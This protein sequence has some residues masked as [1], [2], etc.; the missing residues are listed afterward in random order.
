MWKKPKTSYIVERREY[1]TIHFMRPYLTVADLSLCPRCCGV[2]SDAM[3]EQ[4]GFV[5]EYV[6]TIVCNDDS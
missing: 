4:R 3:V 6:Q 5:Q 1:Y 2:V